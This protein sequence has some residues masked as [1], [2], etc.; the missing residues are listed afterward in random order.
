MTNRLN[1]GELTR[2]DL[3]EPDVLALKG[4]AKWLK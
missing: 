1:T 4:W 3:L 2:S